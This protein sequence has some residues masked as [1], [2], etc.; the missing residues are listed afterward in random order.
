M[1]STRSSTWCLQRG[2]RGSSPTRA[3]SGSAMSIGP[4]SATASVR[5]VRSSKVPSMHVPASFDYA[6]IQ[7]VP[8]VERGEYI[9][10]G[11]ILFCRVLRF[12][13]AGMDLDEGRLLAL[14]PD[15]DLDGV[16][17]H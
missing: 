15:I 10:V 9:N 14:A 7:V 12:L 1:P 16:R 4:T 8:R 2:S 11:V 3:P 6:V 17:R 5:H 13:G